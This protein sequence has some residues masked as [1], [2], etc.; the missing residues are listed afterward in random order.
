LN[1]KSTLDRNMSTP[2]IRQP[3]K[4]RVVHLS[5]VNDIRVGTPAHIPTFKPLSA[6]HPEAPKPKSIVADYTF[7]EYKAAGLNIEDQ[8]KLI[9]DLRSEMPI[10]DRDEV[11]NLLLQ[12]L[13]Q[14]LELT[15]FP[16]CKMMHL[17]PTA[18]KRM[19][20]DQFRKAYGPEMDV[21]V[22]TNMG[23]A[24]VE[25]LPRERASES[26]KEEEEGHDVATVKEGAL[27]TCQVAVTHTPDSHPSKKA[28]QT[29]LNAVQKEVKAYAARKKRG[30]QGCKIVTLLSVSITRKWEALDGGL[31]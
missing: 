11:D 19:L 20:D 21:A 25:E 14:Q 4:K 2:Q 8:H 23:L 30:K 15:I 29:Q 26:F 3:K 16:T 10:I 27:E 12:S 28:K 31:A 17:D 1:R 22:L 5:G 13:A 7:E 6:I 18:V 24:R 9:G